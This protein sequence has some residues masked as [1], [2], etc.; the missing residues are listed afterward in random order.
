MAKVVGPK[1]A[2]EALLGVAQGAGHDPRIADEGVYSFLLIQ[3]L[4]KIG[5][6]VEVCQVQLCYQNLSLQP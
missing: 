2:L 1:L 3:H 5:N 4:C 6:A